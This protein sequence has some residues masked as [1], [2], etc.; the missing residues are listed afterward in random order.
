MNRKEELEQ[1]DPFNVSFKS[2]PCSRFRVSARYSKAAIA[3][4]PNG[5]SGD[6]ARSALC[7]ARL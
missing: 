1:M 4:I 2:L 7:L 6:R 5:A 3:A